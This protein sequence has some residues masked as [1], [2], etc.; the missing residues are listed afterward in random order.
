MKIVG[1]SPNLKVV[2]PV[3]GPPSSKNRSKIESIF[4]SQE[5]LHPENVPFSRFPWLAPLLAPSRGH[6]DLQRIL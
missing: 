6:E 5:D 3:L 2:D 1:Y 4:L